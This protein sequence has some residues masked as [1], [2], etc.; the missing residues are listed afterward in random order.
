MKTHPATEEANTGAQAL[1]S[2]EPLLMRQMAHVLG[3]DGVLE[4]A[5][6]AAAAER[7]AGCTD[8]S[9][10]RHWLEIAAIGG[11]DHAPRFCRNADTFEELATEAPSTF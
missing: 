9:D 11:A 4:G 10:C 7:C 2:G 6:R 5:A 1:A 3:I 8:L